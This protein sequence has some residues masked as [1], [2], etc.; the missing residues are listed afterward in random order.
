MLRFFL[1][2]LVQFSVKEIP[3]PG[4]K[5]IFPRFLNYAI[6]AKIIVIDGF[7]PSLELNSGTLRERNNPVPVI[8]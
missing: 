1:F 2:F 6:D 4:K 8:D 3:V 5:P 7:P